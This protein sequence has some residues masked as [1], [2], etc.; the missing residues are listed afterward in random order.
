MKDI[1]TKIKLCPSSPYSASKGTGSLGKKLPPHLWPARIVVILFQ[2]LWASPTR[3]KVNPN[4]YQQGTQ[5]PADTHLWKRRKHPRLAL[6][7]RPLYGDRLCL[8]KGK[9]GECH[10]RKQ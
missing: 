1:L 3:R 5:P 6:C 7:R 4:H 8:E 2:Q 10:W 9:R